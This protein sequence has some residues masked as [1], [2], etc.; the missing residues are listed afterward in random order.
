MTI[1]GSKEECERFVAGVHHEEVEEKIYDWTTSP[2][3]ETGTKMVTHLGILRG[4]IPCPQELHE[5][6][7]PVQEEQAELAMQMIAK[8]G[9]SNWYDWE[10][11]NWGVKWGDCH[12]HILDESD[13][14]LPDGS[15]KVDYQFDTPWGTADNAFL[16]ISAM[17]PTLRFDFFG[18]I[19][20][21]ASIPSHRSRRASM[22]ALMISE[23][24]C[25]IPVSMIR[26]GFIRQTSS[27]IATISCGYWIIGRPSHS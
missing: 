3:T 24:P 17:F 14:E 8:Y 5:V 6:T 20:D 16:K 25:A 11:E 9:A 12:T 10:Y 2:A 18:S 27:C 22:E 7:A 23:P 13:N 4:Y 26:S 1:T 15:Y 21:P 19:V